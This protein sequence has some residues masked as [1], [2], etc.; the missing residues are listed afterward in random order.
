MLKIEGW[1]IDGTRG[2][3]IAAALAP[4]DGDVVLKKIKPSA[5]HG[6]PLLGLL[7]SAGIDT[8]V[9]TGGSTSNCIRATAIE[10]TSYNFRTIVPSDAVFDR[11]QLSHEVSL[12]DI[13][14]QIG[15]V[16]RSEEVIAWLSSLPPHKE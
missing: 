10:S 11:I 1:Y 5:F 9:I 15:D 4:K 13:D 16:V 8:V 14:R 3:E 12:M 2:A 6:T 7:L